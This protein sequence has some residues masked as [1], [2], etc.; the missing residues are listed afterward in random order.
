M[1]LYEINASNKMSLSLASATEI[2]LEFEFEKEFELCL[3]QFEMYYPYHAHPMHDLV[4]SIES[5][6]DKLD[7]FIEFTATYLDTSDLSAI[8]VI[9]KN[10]K[11]RKRL[12][13]MLQKIA[14]LN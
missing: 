9:N 11:F 12:M 7:E 1:N 6:I 8:I 10:K 4:S 14:E 5:L 13:E 2:P 3:I